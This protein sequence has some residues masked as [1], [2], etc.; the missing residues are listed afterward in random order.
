M[1]MEQQEFLDHAFQIVEQ[2]QKQDA[3]LR[4]LGAVAFYLHCPAY[5]SFQVKA[6]RHFTDLDFAA[7]FKHYDAIHKI[8]EDLGFQEDREV[9]VVYAR[10]RLV[11]DDLKSFLHVDIFFDKLDFCH[12][13]PWAKRLEVDSPTI[14]LAELLV[15][16]MQIVKLNEKDVIDTLMLVREHPIDYGDSETINAKRIADLCAQ[17]WGLW[18]TLTMN[19]QKTSD[20]SQQYTWLEKDDREVIQ[21]R[22]KELLDIIN[23]QPK[24][25]AWKLRNQIG[26]RIKWYKEVQEINQ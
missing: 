8:F 22:I 12:P 2:G 7:Y 1:Q 13:I 4:L 18:R 3:I 15:E 21:D 23:S 5:G 20:L 25:T 6:N 19:L 17:D 24:S 14:P 16:K 26:D 9:A 10:H 11:F